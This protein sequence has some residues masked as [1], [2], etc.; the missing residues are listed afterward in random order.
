MYVVSIA[1]SWVS[2]EKR[3]ISR[4]HLTLLTHGDAVSVSGSK[5]SSETIGD[6]GYIGSQQRRKGVCSEKRAAFERRYVRG[7]DVYAWTNRSYS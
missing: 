6:M 1:G 2:M 7:L 5:E 4:A 3:R